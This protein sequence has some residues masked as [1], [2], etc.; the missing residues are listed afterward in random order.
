M[1]GCVLKICI[2]QVVICL[3]T[4]LLDKAPSELQNTVQAERYSLWTLNRSQCLKLLKL[5]IKCT[6]L[7]TTASIA[8][9][10]SWEFFQQTLNSLVATDAPNQISN[11]NVILKTWSLGFE[12]CQIVKNRKCDKVFHAANSTKSHNI[13]AGC[14]LCKCWEKNSRGSQRTPPGTST[15]NK[16]GTV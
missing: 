8:I 9:Y 1:Q 4:S 3:I 7:N 12:F 16:N 13:P 2:F 10:T 5:P 6:V 11:L 15:P 14:W